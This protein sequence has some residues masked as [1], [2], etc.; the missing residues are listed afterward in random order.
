MVMVAAT[1]VRAVWVVAMTANDTDLF[2]NT[3][4]TENAKPKRKRPRKVNDM[5]AVEEVLDRARTDNGYVLAG[6]ADRV[7]R[8]IDPDANKITTVPDHEAIVVEQLIRQKWLTVGGQHLYVWRNRREGFGHSVLV[9]RSTRDAMNRWAHL[10]ARPA[11]KD[12]G[13]VRHIGRPM[14][15]IA[16]AT[17]LQ[18]SV[19]MY[20]GARVRYS[21]HQDDDPPTCPECMRRAGW[22]SD[23]GELHDSL[24]GK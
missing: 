18:D 2:G 24:N 1:P 19:L 10:K 12:N 5:A 13:S 17:G 20:C 11:V 15:G 9:P 21:D 4:G 14:S 16:N 23:R 3:V 8:V 22:S 6:V 7:C